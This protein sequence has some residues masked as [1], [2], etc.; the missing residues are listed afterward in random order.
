MKEL[1]MVR[2]RTSADCWARA[3][4][5]QTLNERRARAGAGPFAA[6]GFVGAAAEQAGGRATRCRLTSK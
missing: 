5:R 3:A 2:A 1:A 6:Y 4:D